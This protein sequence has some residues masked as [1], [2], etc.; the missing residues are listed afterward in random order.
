MAEL[1]AHTENSGVP[2]YV[3]QSRFFIDTS[4][5]QTENLKKF[6]RT[7]ERE[8][9]EA[10]NKISSNSLAI[11]VKEQCYESDRQQVKPH[12][13]PRKLKIHSN[14]VSSLV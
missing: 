9:I 3:K 1:G 4:A 2:F 13:F 5:P 14:L 11:D 8:K 12:I 10:T 7:K 6:R